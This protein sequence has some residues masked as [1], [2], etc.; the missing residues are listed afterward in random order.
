MRLRTF[1]GRSTAEAMAAV[2]AQLGPDAVIV[3]AQDDGAGNTRV[4]AALD[5]GDATSGHIA[6]DAV[7]GKAL[8]FHAPPPPL[9]ARLIDAA[10]ASGHDAATEA[11][12]AGLA[13]TLRFAPLGDRDRAILLVGAPGSGKTVSAAKLATRDL[14][15]G[16][17]VRLITTDLARAGGVAQLETFAKI[18]GVPFAMA[19]DSAA[20]GSMV[21]LA[22]AQERL[23][24]DT[25]GIN[26]FSAGDRREIAALI[27]AS[28]AE[29]LLVFAAGAE[30]GDGTERA[31]IFADLGCAR[32]IVTQLDATRRLGSMLAI[33]DTARLA[34][35]E[36]G[37]APDIADGIMPFT[38]VLLAHLLLPKGPP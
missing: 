26:P 10:L 35:A 4:T 17:R 27:G 29:P 36:A 38:P 9:R 13:G 18:L 16:R 11:M 12:A 21:T 23:I 32:A 19:D 15:A 34:F 24:I 2:R 14:L 22:D 37:I 25:P 30:A 28:A 20:L 3:S 31:K 6:L 33:A 1:I 7:I 5:E 8:D